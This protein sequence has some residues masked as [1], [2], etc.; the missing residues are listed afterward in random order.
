MLFSI[1]EV[2]RLDVRYV[3]HWNYYA[4]D[5]F[6]ETPRAALRPENQQESADV[7]VFLGVVGGEN[8]EN[9]ISLIINY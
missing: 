5:F 9:A 8:R 2:V 3:F 6:H 7:Y 4:V 1:R